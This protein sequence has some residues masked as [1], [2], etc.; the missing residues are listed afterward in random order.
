MCLWCFARRE[1]LEVALYASLLEVGGWEKVARLFT[2]CEMRERFQ[3]CNEC[4]LIDTV[5]L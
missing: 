1:W 2:F 3:I 4:L 5:M